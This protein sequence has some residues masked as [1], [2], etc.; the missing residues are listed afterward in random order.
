MEF[1][2]IVQN[3]VIVVPGGCPLPEGTAVTVS[4]ESP[5]P[6]KKGQRVKIPLVDDGEPG[7]TFLNSQRIAEILDDEDVASARCERLDRNDIS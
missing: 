3:G 4:C 6:I 2:G 5:A 7:T 1:N